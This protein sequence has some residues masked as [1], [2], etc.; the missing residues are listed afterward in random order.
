MKK[1]IAVLLLLSSPI[2]A[3]PPIILEHPPTFDLL[4]KTNI[5]DGVLTWKPEGYWSGTVGAKR[6]N[7]K[8]LPGPSVRWGIG[9][10]WDRLPFTS[11][12]QNS[13]IYIRFE[14]RSNFTALSTADT[15]PFDVNGTITQCRK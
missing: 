9:D 8:V 1:Y 10:Q 15:I 13:P 2:L 12:V 3:D 5:G 11:T 6:L 7:L 4:A 14:I